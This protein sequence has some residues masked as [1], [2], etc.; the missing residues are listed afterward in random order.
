MRLLAGYVIGGDKWDGWIMHKEVLYSPEGR[1]F[2]PH[3]LRY[4]SYYFSMARRWLREEK[5]KQVRSLPNL[6]EQ[7]LVTHAASEPGEL[8]TIGDRSLPG[9]DPIC[10]QKE[11]EIPTGTAAG[12]PCRDTASP[13][14]AE[15]FREAV[16]VILQQFVEQGAKLGLAKMPPGAC[17]P[18]PSNGLMI[19]RWQTADSLPSAA[20]DTLYAEAR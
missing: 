1:A 16:S 19:G 20:N 2:E 5:V 14:A 18:S 9:Q 3:E 7:P 6:E 4:I 15:P 12:L 11:G 17:A 8:V 10:H 13:F